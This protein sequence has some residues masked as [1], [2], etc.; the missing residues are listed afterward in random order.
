VNYTGTGLLTRF[1]A[2]GT[3]Q[4]CT[5]LDLDLAHGII[6]LSDVGTNTLWR[7]PLGGGSAAPVLKDLS[8]TAK[9]VRWFSGP[10][11]RPSPGLTGIKLSGTNVVLSAT[12]GFVG[13]TYYVLTSTNLALPLSQWLPLASN[14]LGA[15]GSFTINAT[16]AIA[17]F[18]KQF[19]LL[20]V[21]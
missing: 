3:V 4:R 13:G 14:V 15:G 17:P 5:A 12:N 6:Y 18:P 21:Q 1:T 8:A 7:I 10:S 16:N 11:T 2:S 9:K 20:R 19:Y